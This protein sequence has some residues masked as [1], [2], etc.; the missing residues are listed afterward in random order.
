MSV[1]VKVTGKTSFVPF[2]VT[3]GRCEAVLEVTS[4]D[5]VKAERID[6]PGEIGDGFV[7]LTVVCPVDGHIVNVPEKYRA[8]IL[9]LKNLS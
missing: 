8:M 9:K 3:C 1:I 4:I 7:I 5:D 6:Q 2:E